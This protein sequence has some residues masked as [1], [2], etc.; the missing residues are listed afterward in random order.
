M[1]ER[2]EV[3]GGMTAAAKHANLFAGSMRK[4]RERVLRGGSWN[5]NGRNLRSAYRN[6]KSPDNRNDNIGLRLAGAFS[7]A[8]GSKSQHAVRFRLTRAGGQNPGPR[9]GSKPDAQPL[10]QGRP[11]STVGASGRR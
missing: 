9:R 6:G 8:G 10:P 11:F 3:S 2:L 1:P 5:N 4:C 7:I